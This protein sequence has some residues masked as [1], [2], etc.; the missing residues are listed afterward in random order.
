MKGGNQFHQRSWRTAGCLLFARYR[1]C[2]FNG[3]AFLTISSVQKL[4]FAEKSRLLRWIVA[5]YFR[6]RE[7]L[8]YGHRR[9]SVTVLVSARRAAGCRSAG[10]LSPKADR[11]SLGCVGSGHSLCRDTEWP[12]SGQGY[13]PGSYRQTHGKPWAGA[14]WPSGQPVLDRSAARVLQGGEWAS[15]SRSNGRKAPGAIDA[16]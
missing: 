12:R 16:Q 5:F 15:S 6:A 14:A 4:F 2:R 10:L 13:R 9:S 3:S 8:S 7:N 1:P 11:L